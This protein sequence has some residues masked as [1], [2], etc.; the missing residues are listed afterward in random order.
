MCRA[1]KDVTRE[2]QIELGVVHDEHFY[3][4]DVFRSDFFLVARVL[5]YYLLFLVCLPDLIISRLKTI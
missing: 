5:L 3:S 2:N 1:K 4:L